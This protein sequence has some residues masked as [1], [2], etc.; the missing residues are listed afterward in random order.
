[1]VNSK[2]KHHHYSSNRSHA[3]ENRRSARRIMNLETLEEPW[4]L[5][6][7]SIHRAYLRTIGD[8]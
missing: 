7:L 5:L 4:C 2:R 8:C 1:M 3:T 6:E